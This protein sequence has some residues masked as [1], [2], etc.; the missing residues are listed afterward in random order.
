M[1]MSYVFTIGLVGWWLGAVGVPSAWGAYSSIQH[2]LLD[3]VPD[4][5][6]SGG[7]LRVESPIGA[8]N[9]VALNDSALGT[10]TGAVN[11][12]VYLETYYVRYDPIRGAIFDGGAFSLRFDYGGTTGQTYEISGPIDTFEALVTGAGPVYWVIEA[13]GIWQSTTVNLPGSN[14]WPAQAGWSS[15]RT[16]TIAVPE[17]L[18]AFDWAS[19]SFDTGEFVYTLVPYPEPATL[20]LFMLSG[21][22]WVAKRP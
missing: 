10:P 15:F 11:V 18:S 4:T 6:Y 9:D 21:A 19:D 8:N 20:A 17:D 14:Y 2:N 22:W 7:V 1:R 12:S 13:E 16:G 5:S 3:G